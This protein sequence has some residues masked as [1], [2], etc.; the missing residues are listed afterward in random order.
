M[1]TPI[2]KTP[3][4][5]DA[6]IESWDRQQELYVAEREQR[7][8]VVVDTVAAIVG[9]N[10]IR[11]LDLGCGPGALGTRML[12][13]MPTATYIGVDI[14]P[15]LLRLAEEVGGRYGDRF[16][17]RAA[18]LVSTGWADGLAPQSFDAIVSTTALH[19]LGAGALS[20]VF[21]TCRALLHDGGVFVNADN[22]RYAPTASRLQALSDRLEADHRQRAAVEGAQTW[23]EWWDRAR[24]DDALGPLCVER[25]AI[26]PPRPVTDDGDAPPPLLDLYIGLLHDAGFA[27]VDT[28]WQRFDDRVLVALPQP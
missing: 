21:R 20:E 8:G 19:W 15:V 6:W 10:G 1:T 22:L 26:Y 2:V 18:N 14:D 12:D 4:A 5:I 23:S 25:D 27:V 9:D 7:F 17:L 13:R 24:A 16:T 28:V 11:I 3:Y